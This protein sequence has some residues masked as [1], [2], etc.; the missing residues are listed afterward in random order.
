M[1]PEQIPDRDT[2]REQL[3]ATLHVWLLVIDLARNAEAADS[4]ALSE[5]ACLLAAMQAQLDAIDRRLLPKAWSFVEAL[6]QLHE[7]KDGR[8]NSLAGFL[9]SR[10]DSL[11]SLLAP[12]NLR[13]GAD[14]ELSCE[15][16]GAL[17]QPD[18]D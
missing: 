8:W 18:L 15:S 2:L 4:S 10:G 1:T 7:A 17:A 11:S 6:R 16:I 5:L 9:G 14:G 3:V 13:A 12:V